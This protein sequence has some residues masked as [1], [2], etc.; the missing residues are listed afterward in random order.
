MKIRANDGAQLTVE[1]RPTDR[2]SVVMTIAGIE[3]AFNPY[4]AVGIADRLVDAAERVSSVI[5]DQQEG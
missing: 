1:H 5:T 3:F 2:R 4:E